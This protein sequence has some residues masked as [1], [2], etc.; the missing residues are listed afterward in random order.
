MTGKCG[1]MD[2]SNPC[3]CNKKTKLMMNAGHVDPNN[4]VFTKESSPTNRSHCSAKSG[5]A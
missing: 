5:R 4:L 3:H 1:L 2:K